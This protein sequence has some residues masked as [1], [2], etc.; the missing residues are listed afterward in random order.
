MVLEPNDPEVLQHIVEPLVMG[1]TLNFS[2]K[3]DIQSNYW[4]AKYH[5]YMPDALNHLD[6]GTVLTATTDELHPDARKLG[7]QS[8]ST[9]GVPLMNI[10]NSQT[11]ADLVVEKLVRC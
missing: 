9:F 8:V 4:L 10:S 7:V 5:V 2:S 11:L 6:D 1:A 3:P